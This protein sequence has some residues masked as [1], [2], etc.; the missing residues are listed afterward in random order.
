M[1]SEPTVLRGLRREL[2][3][4]LFEELAGLQC[5]LE[6]ILGYIGTTE[7]KLDA[8]CR[9]NY[10]RP[11]GEMIRMISQD[12]LIAIRRAGFDQLKKSAT[13]IT[14]QFNRFLSGAGKD[15][16]EVAEKALQALTAAMTPDRDMVRTLFDPPAQEEKTP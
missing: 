4:E 12:G 3:R 13:V 7:K 5:T 6:E 16:R 14:Q 11:L 10:R 8:W 1:A 15:P 9:K 2:T